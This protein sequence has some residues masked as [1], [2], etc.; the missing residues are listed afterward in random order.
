MALIQINYASEALACQTN[1][2]VLLPEDPA[3]MRGE[4][5][6]YRTLYLLHGLTDDNLGWFRYTSIESVVRGTD[7]AVVMPAVDHGFYTDMAHGHPYFTFVSEELPRYLQSILPLSPAREDTF[8]AGNSMGGYGAMKLALTHPERYAKAA[9]FSGVLDIQDFVDTRHIAGFDPTCAFGED[10]AV[11][12][13][14]NDVLQLLRDRVAE[15]ADLP[16]LYLFCGKG[17][18]LLNESRTFDALCRELGVPVTYDEGE[19]EHLW[20]T[21]E[22]HVRELVDWL[23]A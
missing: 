19:G 22:H 2:T 14:E 12:G 6:K 3:Q 21:W 8:V 18:I 17:D 20:V 23:L 9:A 7:L 11:A 4:R 16:G 10:L 1:V 13:T 5:K 15:G